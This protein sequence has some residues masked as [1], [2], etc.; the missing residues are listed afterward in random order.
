LRRVR[1][2]D[3]DIQLAERAGELRYAATGSCRAFA[4]NAEDGVL[5]AV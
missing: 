2:N 5:V 1:A 3:V 4:R